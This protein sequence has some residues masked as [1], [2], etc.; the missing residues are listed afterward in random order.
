M[1][2]T[3]NDLRALP[4]PTLLQVDHAAAWAQRNARLKALLALRG[5][6]FDVD[7]L[8]TSPLVVTE[9]AGAYRDVLRAQEIN[10]IS[11]KRLVAFAADGDLD[12]LGAGVSTPRK[13]LVADPRPRVPGTD[14]V[15]DWET[16]DDYRPRIANALERPSTAGSAS[17]YREH[18]LLI[19]G[20]KD[21]A[22]RRPGP[23]RVQVYVLALT[24]APS[25]ALLAAVTAELSAEDVRPQ[26]DVVEV[27]PAGVITVN[28]TGVYDLYPGADTATVTALGDA[29]MAA[30]IDRHFAL[31]HDI[32]LDGLKAAAM[33]EGVKRF[34]PSINGQAADL[35]L[36]GTQAPIRG[37]ISTTVSPTRD[38]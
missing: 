22:I 25:D 1:T 6:D 30:Y 5:I 11:L 3:L 9:E 15:A 2:V 28:V 23:P 36:D 32:T 34:A 27:L 17:G 12:Q 37:T 26:N 18:A 19:S 4:A 8:E 29:G 16:D 14:S 38:V 35:V 31:G 21:A 24:G 10:E 7:S 33:V 20:V 13:A